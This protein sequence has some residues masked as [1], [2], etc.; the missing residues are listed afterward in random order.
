MLIRSAAISRVSDPAIRHFSGIAILVRYR[1]PGNF[2]GQ[3]I[4]VKLPAFNMFG[5]SL[6]DLS[7]LAA[8]TYTLTGA[9]AIAAVTIPI[10]FLA[11]PQP[12]QPITRH[13]FGQA[14]SFP[15]GVTGSTCSAGRP[16]AAAQMHDIAKN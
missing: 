2:V 7:G 14:L 3:T 12:G 8:D 11:S 1:Y 5:Q 9:G 16:A 10:Q 4:H 15:A 13:T 6:Q